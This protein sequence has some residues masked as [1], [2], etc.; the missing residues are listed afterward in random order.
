MSALIRLACVGGLI[1]LTAAFSAF[2]VVFDWLAHFRVQY[3]VLLFAAL[4]L[5]AY[6]HQ[7]TATLILSMCLAFH[8]TTIYSSLRGLN[9][10]TV[11]KSNTLRVM[12]SNVWAGNTDYARYIHYVETADPD[13]IV[14]QEYTTAWDDALTTQLV[15][16]PHTLTFPEENPFGIA[17]FSKYPLSDGRAFLVSRNTTPSIDVTVDVNG[18]ALKIL[19]THPLP[20]VSQATHDLRN[21]HL[22]ALAEFIRYESGPIIV[23]GDLNITPWSQPFQHLVTRAGLLD[24][25]RGH[26][27]LPTWPS[28]FFPLQ[29]PID[30]I[31]VKPSIAVTEVENSGGV[32]SD[33]RSL[34]ATV[35]F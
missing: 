19:G 17:V 11:P 26:G 12:T 7:H 16:Y 13:V 22:E 29:I 20:P 10:V 9:F 27:I 32:G 14:I 25:R 24:A 34:T 33:H 2:H 8:S 6:Q 35:E 28:W 4:I 3:A 1:S 31:L 30:H 5:S 15:H 18:T 23:M 21:E